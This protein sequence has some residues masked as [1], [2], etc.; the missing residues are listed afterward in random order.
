MATIAGENV[1]RAL[2]GA[3]AAAARLTATPPSEALIGDYPAP[4][5]APAEDDD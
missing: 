3:E 2:R 4:A 1:L 5:P